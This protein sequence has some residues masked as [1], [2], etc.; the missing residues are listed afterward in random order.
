MG[1]FRRVFDGGAARDFYPKLKEERGKEQ[2]TIAWSHGEVGYSRVGALETRKVAAMTDRARVVLNDCR[3][4]LSKHTSGLQ[5][6]EFRVSWVALV[7]LLRTVGYVLNEEDSTRS[8]SL[9]QAIDSAWADLKR[10]KPKPEIFWEFIDK[11]RQSV[12]HCYRVGVSRMASEPATP[13][14][15]NISFDL[16]SMEGKTGRVARVRFS[17]PMVITSKIA[18][19]HFS[20]RNELEVAAEAV[21][22]WQQYLDRV[23]CEAARLEKLKT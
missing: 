17:G 3:C 19:G 1:R 12:L 15:L 11:E 14:R 20:G 4:A 8:A 16:G 23:D 10:T 22:W 2:A 9:E 13:G 21:E 6:E 7:S 5:G 18:L